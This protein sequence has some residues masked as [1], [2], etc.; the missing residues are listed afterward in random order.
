MG[1]STVQRIAEPA[2]DQPY[3]A[4]SEEQPRT[5]EREE[6]RGGGPAAVLAAV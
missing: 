6:E 5:G 1:S 2:A 4:R 3:D